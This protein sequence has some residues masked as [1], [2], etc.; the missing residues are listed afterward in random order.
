MIVNQPLYS[1]GKS[2]PKKDENLPLVVSPPEN[3]E[4]C[5]I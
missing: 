3:S 4:K 1:G 5:N 2:N